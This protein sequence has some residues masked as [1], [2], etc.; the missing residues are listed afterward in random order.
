MK[1]IASGE[2]FFTNN[3]AHCILIEAYDFKEALGIYRACF[4]DDLA[5]NIDHTAKAVGYP[6][7]THN[8]VEHGSSHHAVP[9]GD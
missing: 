1:Y 8:H 9:I 5:I 3:A 6:V 4:P 2:D 7:P